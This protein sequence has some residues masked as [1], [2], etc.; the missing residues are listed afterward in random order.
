MLEKFLKLIMFKNLIEVFFF[1]FSKL[2]TTI[3]SRNE[4]QQTSIAPP[5]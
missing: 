2:I 3:S 5:K 4:I 1:L